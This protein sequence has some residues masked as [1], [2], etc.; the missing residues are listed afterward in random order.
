MMR[1]LTLA[2]AACACAACMQPS[3]PIDYVDPFIGTG[4]HGHTYPGATT[5]FGMVQSQGPCPK[6]GG[7]GKIIH[8]P[9]PTCKGKANVRR[10]RKLSVNIPAGIDD[11]QT[12][13]MK[14]QGNAGRDGGPAG[15]LLV[16]VSVRRHETFERDGTSVLSSAN[17]SFAQAA[18]GADI[19]VPTLD[20]KVK[21]T[22]PEGTQP[23]TVFRLRGK[24][25]PFL[26]GSG[27][28]DQ[29]VTVNVVVPKNMTA[30]QKDA[31]RE[32]AKAMDGRAPESSSIFGRKKK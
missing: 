1:T 7:T 25:I 13:S 17:V 9:C 32:Y 20:G 29:Y 4:F 8:Q 24:G 26:R 2:L 15:D 19:E 10:N 23:G 14:G 3:D 18:L 16:T 21:L 6:C 12:I 30:A 11:G 5:P 22:I 28:G 31:L 27:R